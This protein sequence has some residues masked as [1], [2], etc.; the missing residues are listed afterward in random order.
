MRE[1]L[2]LVAVVVDRMGGASGDIGKIA[3]RTMGCPR[4]R[5][6]GGVLVRG[7]DVAGPLLARWM[8]RR[9]MLRGEFEPDRWQEA[10]RRKS[11]RAKREPRDPRPDPT[12]ARGAR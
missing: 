3:V 6:I 9:V 10:E 11:E 7:R 1:H 4:A 2:A 8:R 12:A 5:V